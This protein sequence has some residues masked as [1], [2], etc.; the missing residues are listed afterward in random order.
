MAYFNQ[1]ITHRWPQYDVFGHNEDSGYYYNELR[2]QCI[3]IKEA[4]TKNEQAR[5]G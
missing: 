2:Q 5:F 1:I 3:K 4:L